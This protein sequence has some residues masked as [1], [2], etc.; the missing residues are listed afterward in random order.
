MEYFDFEKKFRMKRDSGIKKHGKKNHK[1]Q[2]KKAKKQKALKSQTC[3]NSAVN[4][5]PNGLNPYDISSIDITLRLVITLTLSDWLCR[6]EVW[7]ASVK[8]SKNQWPKRIRLAIFNAAIPANWFIFCFWSFI[9]DETW[10]GKIA[11][12]FKCSIWKI[13]VF[14]SWRRKRIFSCWNWNLYRQGWFPKFLLPLLLCGH[15]AW[16]ISYAA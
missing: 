14:I 13:L 3:S 9:F 7:L 12:I 8:T 16:V 4:S 10:L 6:Y 5:C 11:T 15:D 1:N 2:H